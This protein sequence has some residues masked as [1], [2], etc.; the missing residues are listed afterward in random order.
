M[1][2]QIEFRTDLPK[3]NV[4]KILRR[5]LR[6]EKKRPRRPEAAIG[7]ARF[8]WLTL[9]LQHDSTPADILAFWRDAGPDRWYSHDD[10]FD[11]EVAPPLS[12]AVAMQAAAGDL[13]VMGSQRRRRA[14]A[15]SSC[16]TSFPATCSA[17][18]CA[19]LPAIAS[20]A[21]LRD[22]AIERGVD[23]RGSI[24][25][26]QRIPLYAADAFGAPRRPGALHRAVRA[27]PAIPTT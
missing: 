24:Q 20:R 9:W 17:T 12:R 10:A 2:K 8:A 7:R 14:G 26:L 16:S 15:R 4:G 27:Q 6:D 25:Q 21:T 1:P 22:R 5:E 18:T 3:T 23:Q 19:P 11:A 13:V